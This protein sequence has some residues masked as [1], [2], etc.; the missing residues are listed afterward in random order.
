M[1]FDR[2][3]ELVDMECDCPYAE[4]GEYCKH[5][6]AVLCYESYGAVLGVEEK[7]D[8]G[9]NPQ[10][11]QKPKKDSRLATVSKTR[12]NLEILKEEIKKIIARYKR[13]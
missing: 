5:M 10:E 9:N 1:E 13:Q 6:A 7:R 11:S 4:N 12:L 8:A 2:S 3:G